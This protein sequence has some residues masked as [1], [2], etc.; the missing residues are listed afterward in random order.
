MIPMFN[1]KR[2]RE[3]K[4]QDESA[5]RKVAREI[6]EEAA[7]Q[8]GGFPKDELRLQL[9]GGWGREFAHQLFGTPRRSRRGRSR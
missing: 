6:R 2:S 4:K 1:R 7:R 9:I 3:M 8:I 5:L